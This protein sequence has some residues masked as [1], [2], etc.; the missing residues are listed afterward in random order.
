MEA[1]HAVFG[2]YLMCDFL[3]GPRPWKLAWIINT[4]KGTTLAVALFIIFH[5]HIQTVT[6]Y[7]Y[8]GLHGA[9]GFI[10]VRNTALFRDG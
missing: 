6:A 2:S 10:W 3:G 7:V 5:F 1:L 8:A 4:F 9:Y